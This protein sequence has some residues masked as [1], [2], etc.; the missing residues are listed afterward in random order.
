MMMSALYAPLSASAQQITD[1]LVKHGA[2]DIR[3]TTTRRHRVFIST[4]D[5]VNRVGRS[6]PDLIVVPPESMSETVQSP[7]PAVQSAPATSPKKQTSPQRSRPSDDAVSDD[8]PKKRRGRPPKRRTDSDV[9]SSDPPRTTKREG[10]ND[11]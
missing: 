6:R 4:S 1:L 10:S 3:V 5:A 9:E 2:E 7:N 8:K 11:G